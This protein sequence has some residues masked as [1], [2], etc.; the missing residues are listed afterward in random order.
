M[1]L[2]SYWTTLVLFTKRVVLILH[3]NI[4][5]LRGSICTRCCKGLEV[6]KKPSYMV[7]GGVCSRAY[8]INK[9]PSSRIT[10]KTP[11]EMLFGKEPSLDH[12][13]VKRCL[14]YATNTHAK[15]KFRPRVIP[16]VFIGYSNLQKGYK[17][18][19]IQEKKD[20]CKL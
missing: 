20:I 12:L 6:S 2:R 7:L 18:F 14:T 15:D 5:L 4:V 3:N 19:D 1:R 11:Y 9:M 8:L 10:N 16:F 17:W 13:K